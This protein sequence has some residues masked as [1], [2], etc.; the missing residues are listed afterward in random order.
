MSERNLLAASPT[1][2]DVMP[3]CTTKAASNASKEE[4]ALEAALSPLQAC[5]KILTWHHEPIILYLFYLFLCSRLTRDPGIVIKVAFMA[6]CSSPFWNQ[7]CNVNACGLPKCEKC[8]LWLQ[9]AC[10]REIQ[11]R[12]PT[13]Q[14]KERQAKAGNLKPIFCCSCSRWMMVNDADF[15]RSSF[16]IP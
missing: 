8:S 13:S 5:L 4:K 10:F 6:G 7:C 2:K 12:W 1:I 9:S 3:N 14:M 15:G 16:Q 11:A